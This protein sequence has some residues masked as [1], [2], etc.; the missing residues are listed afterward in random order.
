MQDA[1]A[2]HQQIAQELNA[3]VSFLSHSSTS[4]NHL[5]KSWQ[6]STQ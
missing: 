3:I 5:A 4:K 6:K 2:E 1:D